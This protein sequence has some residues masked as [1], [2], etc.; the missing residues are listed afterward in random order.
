MQVEIP[1]KIKLRLRKALSIAKRKEIGGILMAEQIEPGKFKII[2][3]TIDAVT[4]SEAHF[5]RSPKHFDQALADFFKKTQENYVRFN[6][7][8]EWHSHPNHPPIPSHT[9]LQSM[10]S[11]IYSERDIPFAIL[12]IVRGAWWGRILCS[13]TLFQQGQHPSPV[14]VKF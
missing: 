3:F 8:G 13:A 2:D 14:D 12:L 5:V 1:H 10:Q 9:D 7:L 4:G 11:L 6:Y